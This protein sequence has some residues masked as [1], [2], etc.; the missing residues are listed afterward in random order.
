MAVY[1]A[2]IFDLDGTLIDSACDIAKALNVGFM[3]NGWPELDPDH[4]ETFLGNGPR[5]L[6]VDILEDLDISYTETQVQRAFEGY[7]QAY[8]DD[9]AGRTRFYP[10]VRE[11]LVALREAGIRLGICTN[12]NH[13]VTG[14]V[15]QQLGLADLFDAAIGADAVPACKP[16]P[17]HLLAVADAMALAEHT[18]A[19][20]GDT[21]VDQQT[22]RAAGVAFF[23]VPWG[24][25][26]QVEISA[27]QR[28]NRLADLLQR[29]PPIAQERI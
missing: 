21:R 28:L 24:G 7:L 4:V 9:P 23:V 22:A 17:G 3:L 20:V 29:S 10:H 13:A 15:L 14:K 18:W 5:R 12:K 25:G 27:A 16:D 11:D 19:Y 2:L 1:N 6:I 26:P 8:M